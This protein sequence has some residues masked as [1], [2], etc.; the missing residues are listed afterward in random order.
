MQFCPHFHGVLIRSHHIEYDDERSKAKSMFNT[1]FFRLYLL[2]SCVYD[3]DFHG[4][5]DCGQPSIHASSYA[6]D[7]FI[8]CR[9]WV[10]REGKFLSLRC[11]ILPPCHSYGAV[12]VELMPLSYVDLTTSKR[13]SPHAQVCQ[14]MLQSNVRSSITR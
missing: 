9:G 4:Y 7:S 13:R 12:I 8:R 6:T 14:R 10:K 5:V 1:M 2:L 3:T 11:Q